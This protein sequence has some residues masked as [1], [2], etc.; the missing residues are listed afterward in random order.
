VTFA[1]PILFDLAGEK[2]LPHLSHKITLTAY[3]GDAAPDNIAVECEDCAEV[4]IAFSPEPEG[5]PIPSQ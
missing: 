4:L 3:G 1:D 2:L 5:E